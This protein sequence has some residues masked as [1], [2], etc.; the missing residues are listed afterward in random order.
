[1]WGPVGINT[2]RGFSLTLAN[3][4]RTD[5]ISAKGYSIISVYSARPD[6]G[7]G[8]AVTVSMFV[9]RFGAAQCIDAALRVACTAQ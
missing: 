2:H 3:T 8:A 9:G 4:S 5:G 7:H 1:M 6:G